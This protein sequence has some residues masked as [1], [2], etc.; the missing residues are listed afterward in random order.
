M[1]REARFWPTCPASRTI[2]VVLSACCNEGST[3]VNRGVPRCRPSADQQAS[4]RD[5]REIPKLTINRRCLRWASAPGWPRVGTEGGGS[6]AARA[7]RHVGSEGVADQGQGSMSFSRRVLH[8]DPCPWPAPRQGRRRVGIPTYP[9][10]CP[11]RGRHTPHLRELVSCPSRA[12]SPGDSRGTTDTNGQNLTE[13]APE[14]FPAHRPLWVAPLQGGA[15]SGASCC[16]VPTRGDALS[17]FASTLHCFGDEVG[18]AAT[19]YDTPRRSPTQ[20]RETSDSH[21]EKMVWQDRPLG[22]WTLGNAVGTDATSPVSG[23]R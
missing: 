12:R 14:H 20:A 15:L 4:T 10:P 5:G 8:M 6:P 22:R 2:T 17:G 18:A 11:A 13:S 19:S 3:T 21:R 7:F 23:L 9:L 16:C 1:G